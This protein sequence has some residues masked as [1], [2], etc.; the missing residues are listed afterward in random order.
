MKGKIR[1]SHYLSVARKT[2]CQQQAAQWSSQE[3]S[4]NNNLRLEIKHNNNTISS[5]WQIMVQAIG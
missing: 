5:F 3:T 2:D 4:K 1:E